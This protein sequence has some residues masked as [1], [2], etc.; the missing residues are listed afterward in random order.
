MFNLCEKQVECVLSSLAFTKF[1]ILN[2]ESLPL[3]LISDASIVWFY[4][5]THM[6][7]VTIL[8]NSKA[9][10]TTNFQ[11][12]SHYSINLF[13]VTRS[14]RKIRAGVTSALANSVAVRLL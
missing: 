4:D 8:S 10:N 9:S 1:S 14:V 3:K 6:P 2:P 12:Q 13:R 7:D 5:D 11:P